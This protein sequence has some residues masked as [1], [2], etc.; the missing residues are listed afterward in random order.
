MHAGCGWLRVLIEW[1]EFLGFGILFRVDFHHRFLV[2]EIC[3]HEIVDFLRLGSRC[4]FRRLAN[5]A[6]GVI[7]IASWRMMGDGA[8]VVVHTLAKRVGEMN[9]MRTRYTLAKRGAVQ[10][11]CLTVV[12]ILLG[13]KTSCGTDQ[14]REGRLVRQNL[15][16]I[17]PKNSVCVLARL[18]IILLRR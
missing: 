5:V 15:A 18:V 10:K 16:V 2:E 8:H 3:T 9:R 1:C 11:F 14:I 12:S 17:I 7:Q 6:S 13:E 4:T